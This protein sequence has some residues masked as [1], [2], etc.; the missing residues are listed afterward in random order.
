MI[1]LYLILKERDRAMR[2]K[3]INIIIDIKAKV[4]M[5]V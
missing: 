5:Y 3:M 2:L 4:V 1:N